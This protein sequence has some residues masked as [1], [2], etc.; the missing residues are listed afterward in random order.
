MQQQPT[1]PSTSSPTAPLGL[2]A[3]AIPRSSAAPPHEWELRPLLSYCPSPAPDNDDT[4]LGRFSC[5]SDPEA[6]WRLHLALGSSSSSQTVRCR[7]DF[8]KLEAHLAALNDC[9]ELCGTSVGVWAASEALGARLPSEQ[10]G[11]EGTTIEPL[12]ADENG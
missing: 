8:E 3:R 11:E 6:N 12:R 9:L 1:R 5:I 7:R 2:A 10:E 4:P